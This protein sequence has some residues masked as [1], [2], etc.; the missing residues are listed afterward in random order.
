[1]TSSE[2]PILVLGA[3]LSGLQAA[4]TL[5]RS[6]RSVTVLEA[7]NRA[8]G[9]VDTRDLGNLTVEMGAEWIGS[10]DARMRSLCN[11]FTLE[12]ID[13]RLNTHLLYDGIY[14][15]PGQWQTDTAWERTL[16]ELVKQ[17]PQLTPKEIA[18]LQNI[19]WW[20][21]LTQ[22]HVS[23]RDVNI[24]DLLR[25]G[26]FGE[27]MRFVPAYDVLYDYAV[28]GNEEAACR[29]TIKG[30]NRRLI[31]AMV[32]EIG[33][34]H[35]H[36]EEE[37]V[38]VTQDTSGVT[39]RTAQGKTYQGSALIVALPT[40]AVT[41]IEWRPALPQTQADAYAEVSYTRILKTAVRF[42]TCFW[43]DETFD[44]VTDQ[45]PGQIYHATPGQQN[46]AALISYAVGDKAF[47]LA[48]MSEADRTEQIRK[49]LAIPFEEQVPPVSETLHYYW[50]DD[51]YTGGAYPLFE[52]S[53][54]TVLQ[55]LLRGIYGKMH[56]AGEHT[57]IRYGFMEGAVESGERAAE[58]VLRAG[59]GNCRSV[60]L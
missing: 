30:G 19:D 10:K 26:D 7:R 14:Q 23:L 1:M 2:L 45:L 8:G 9:R 40:Q 37:V 53:E 46:G 31:D 24:L 4:L 5:K 56:F 27:D 60:T 34:D 18:R 47:I 11:Q 22:H 48:H 58:E 39:V 6:G 3:G 15:R 41:A 35:V 57:A 44:L 29:Y 43:K 54:R 59:H 32:A 17:F 21:F 42:D 50:G 16:V 20:H 49:T 25:S 13:H 52:G 51:P 33:S 36:L 28:G 12:L 55:P 38:Q